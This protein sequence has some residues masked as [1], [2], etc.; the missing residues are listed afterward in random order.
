[1]HLHRLFGYAALLF[2][3]LWVLYIF[4]DSLISYIFLSLLV[5]VVLFA[6]CMYVVLLIK[7]PNLLQSEYYRIEDKKLDIIASKGSDIQFN[8]VDLTPPTK[9]IGDITH[10]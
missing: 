1:M 10:E 7:D 3:H 8:P 4:K 5:I 2:L 6:L 9:E